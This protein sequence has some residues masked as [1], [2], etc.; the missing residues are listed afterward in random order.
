ME[1]FQYN[2]VNVRSRIW[3]DQ[4]SVNLIPV[5][6]ELKLISMTLELESW[7]DLSITQE[8]EMISV[9]Q[10]YP[11]EINL[12]PLLKQELAY[13]HQVLV[14]FGNGVYMVKAGTYCT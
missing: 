6:K 14:Q 4:N 8:F 10:V 12:Y 1:R 7:V 2:M 5:T 9:T 13:I 11:S 3:L